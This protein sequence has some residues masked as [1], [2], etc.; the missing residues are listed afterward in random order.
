MILCTHNSFYLQSLNGSFIACG[1]PIDLYI[2]KNDTYQSVHP[3][4]QSQWNWINQNSIAV[5]TISVEVESPIVYLRL[6]Y[7]K[8]TGENST[9]SNEV[10]LIMS[11][12]AHITYTWLKS[13]YPY[14]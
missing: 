1:G 3:I 14:N 4:H 9:L 8:Q 7:S 2:I 10:M 5:N 12:M 11:K 6:F 13:Y